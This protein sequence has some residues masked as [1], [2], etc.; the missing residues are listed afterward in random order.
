M[1]PRCDKRV[2]KMME[3]G[4]LK[5]LEDYHAHYNST[6]GAPADYTV[7]I[8]Q[9]IGFKEFHRYLTMTGE[10][11]ES[12]EGR[13]ALSAGVKQMK[14]ATRQYSRR[15]AKWMR[16]RFLSKWRATPPVYAV[17]ST[18]AA[19]WSEVRVFDVGRIFCTYLP[20]ST[21]HFISSPLLQKCYDPAVRIVDSVLSGDSPEQSPL[22]PLERPHPAN[23]AEILHCDVCDKDMKGEEQYR[24]HL[25]GN[26]HRRKEGGR[27]KGKTEG[28]FS[29]VIKKFDS[30]DNLA[31]LKRVKQISGLPLH[32]VKD[33]I[34][35]VLKSESVFD[36]RLSVLKRDAQRVAEELGKL[37]LVCAIRP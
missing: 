17:D 16:N 19:K 3:R 27:R 5:E 31:V 11:K 12:D 8:F 35:R 23:M 2:D 25:A 4:M 7:G 18:E 28:R 9:S 32:E 10:E 33:G 30:G 36:L 15:Q 1:L 20:H 24:A 21:V 37:G 14:L 26:K 34:S 6:R 22:P 13:E 29:V